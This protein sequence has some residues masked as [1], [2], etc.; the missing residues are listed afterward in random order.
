MRPTTVPRDGSFAD[1]HVRPEA[2]ES[3]LE[4]LTD[5]MVVALPNTCVQA[6]G[7]EPNINDKHRPKELVS[8][9]PR[10]PRREGRHSP[11]PAEHQ[12]ASTPSP[13]PS[14]RSAQ[15]TRRRRRSGWGASSTSSA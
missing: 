15:T 12:H 4:G 13:Q 3:F 9:P 5:N 11:A 7:L 2:V 10:P 8:S 14:R 6:A 1:L